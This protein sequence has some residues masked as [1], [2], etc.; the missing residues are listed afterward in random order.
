MKKGPIF[1]QIILSVILIVGGYIEKGNWTESKYSIFF[2]S[3]IGE[4][5]H[6]L[7]TVKLDENEISPKNLP[8]LQTSFCPNKS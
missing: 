7:K 1:L 5:K 8:V 6:E 4:S 3:A 2:L